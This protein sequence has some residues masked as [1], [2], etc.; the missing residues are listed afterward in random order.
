M[1]QEDLALRCG[2]V[3]GQGRIGNY[4]RDEREPGR[5]DYLALAA[6]LD[7]PASYLQFGDSDHPLD[8][9]GAEPASRLVFPVAYEN[10][11]ASLGNGRFNDEHHVEVE[12][13]I[14]VPLDLIEKNGWRLQ[15]LRVVQTE[16]QSMA[17]T[18]GDKE[19]VVI[20]LDD[21][22]VMPHRVTGAA[23]IYAIEDADVGLRLKRLSRQP[24]GVIVVRSDN[25]DKV[26]FPDERLGPETR[27][28][29][30]VCYQ[31]REL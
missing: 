12:G 31:A 18:L 6:A 10:V 20:N 3:G 1:S 9:G 27:V 16:G 24:G 23:Q 21:T 5:E 25:P 4:E 28:V 8:E 15:A 11:T 30:R 17:P 29:G 19:P 7:V 14:A 26:S 2:W 13:S 22:R